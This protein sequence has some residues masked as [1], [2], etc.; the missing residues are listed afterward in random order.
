[1]DC[2]RLT[3]L[4]A[5][6]L[7]R[8]A[9]NNGAGGDGFGGSYALKLDAGQFDNQGGGDRSGAAVRGRVVVH[10][11][12]LR[13]SAELAAALAHAVARCR[14][15]AAAHDDGAETAGGAVNE[16]SPVFNA[17]FQQALAV[18][19]Q[20]LFEQ[21]VNGAAASVPP[22]NGVVAV[23][24]PSASGAAATMG[25]WA[26]EGLQQRMQR[27][28]LMLKHPQLQQ[29]L[30]P[31][32]ASGGGGGDDFNLD[33][34]EDDAGAANGDGADAESAALQLAASRE[35]VRAL[36]QR[37]DE[38]ESAHLAA[39]KKVNE[40][41]ESAEW[42]EEALQDEEDEEEKQELAVQVDQARAQFAEAQLEQ[43]RVDSRLKALRKRME[44]MERELPGE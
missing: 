12:R 31:A 26:P 9:D 35:H 27:Y 39:T 40:A 20:Q 19:G 2:T 41:R 14:S 5:R 18:C 13:R 1:M 32:A 21:E 23:A 33:S 16:D 15:L 10:V 28:G 29:A 25:S 11:E 43:Q 3:L 34:D 17:M 42:Y 7:P 24:D 44:E 30:Q 37:L 38:L 8:A 6:S 22:T 36:R 4:A